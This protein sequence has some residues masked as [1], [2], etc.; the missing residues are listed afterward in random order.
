[1]GVVAW[2][3]VRPLLLIA[4]GLVLVV[5]DFRTV[6]LDLLPDLVGWG[7]VAY[8]ASRLS[9]TSAAW[10]AG[11]AGV[12]SVC[13]DFLPYRYVSIDRETGERLPP[14]QQGLGVLPQRVEFDAVS[15]WRL[16]GMTLA[17]IV[18]GLAVWVLLRGLE[19]RAAI[20]DEPRAAAQLRRGRWLVLAV[21]VVPFLVGVGRSLAANDGSF[22]PIWNGGAEYAGLAGLAVFGYLVVVLARDASADWA[23]PRW[24]WRPSPWDELR[25]RRTDRG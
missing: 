12:L 5:F 15:G 11:A 24:L 9:L 22:D 4:G 20:D 8:G 7:A 10:L 19:S 3:S 23:I 17:V 21:W 14:E 1:V 13:S 2:L 25:L 6:S 18:G 16:A